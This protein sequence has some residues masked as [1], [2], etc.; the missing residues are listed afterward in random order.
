MFTYQ[1][2]ERLAK[3]WVD[4]VG[5]GE[6]TI[7]PQHTIDKP[8]GWVFFY[9]HKRFIED[10]DEK[11]QLGGNAPIIVDRVNGELIVTGT[12]RAL[13]DY[14]AEYEATLPPAR[15]QMRP[16]PHEKI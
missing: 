12:G 15:L 5:G 14:L 1:Q 10:R 3:T 4:I 8:Y 13:E 2:A 11:F 6:F 16:E 7:V 9:N